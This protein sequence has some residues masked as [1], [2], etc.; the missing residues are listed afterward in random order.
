MAKSRIKLFVPAAL[1]ALA[2]PNTAYA[3]SI[4]AGD[5]TNVGSGFDK[6]SRL[7][8]ILAQQGDPSRP[9]L[10]LGF[11]S[12]LTNASAFSPRLPQFN[13]AVAI[14]DNPNVFGTIA[15]RIRE[16]SLD[17]KWRRVLQA[18]LSGSPA[19]FAAA[20]RNSDER[21]RLVV[22]NRY[23]NSRVRFAEDSRQYQRADVWTAANE[24]LKRGTGD[25]EDS[26]IAKLQMLRVA[27]FADRDLYLVIL[28]DLVRRADH[29]VAVVRLGGGLFVMDNSTDRVLENEIVTDYR[30]I[31]TFSADGVWTH[32]YKVA[33]VA[34][35]IATATQSEDPQ[36]NLLTM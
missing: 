34:T 7:G 30:P 20:L 25:C 12:G 11:R 32:G 10:N 27:G 13:T 2:M 22:I 19:A 26:A 17:G 36:P 14:S 9:A 16:S 6:P 5:F 18:R 3:D 21:Q 31:L 8:M 4:S 33:S 24:T 1:L 29:A 35:K 28:K 23:V 15:L